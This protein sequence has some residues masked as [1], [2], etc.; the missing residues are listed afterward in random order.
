MLH[1]SHNFLQMGPGAISIRVAQGHHVVY[2]V[3]TLRN[4]RAG[5][6]GN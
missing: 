4:C 6:R 2:G 5:R 3:I 1:F